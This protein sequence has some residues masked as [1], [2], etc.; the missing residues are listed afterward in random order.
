M[1]KTLYTPQ[2]KRYVD[3]LNSH[4]SFTC[5]EDYDA[6]SYE[7]INMFFKE[8]KK[9]APIDDR[10]CR[11]FWVE[12]ERGPISA[13]GD[14][15]EWKDLGEVKNRKEFNQLWLDYYPNPT[16]WFNIYA[17]EDEESD[18]KAIAVNER[19]IIQIGSNIEKKYMREITPFT[20]WLVSCVQDTIEKLKAGTYMPYIRENLPA[21]RRTG[22]ILREDFWDFYDGEKEAYFKGLTETD[23]AEFI[24]YMDEQNEKDIKFDN[25]IHDMTANDFFR[26][27]ALG[28]AAMNYDGCDLTPKEQ[29]KKHA[30]GRDEGLLEIDAD[31]P[32]A[33]KSWLTDRNRGGGHPWEVCRGGNSTHIDLM[34]Y[35]KDDGYFLYLRGSA[36]TRSSEAIKFYLALRRNNIPVI[37]R[38]GSV[39][40]QRVLGTE[41]VGVVP[42][43]VIPR[44]CESRFPDDNI[45]SFINLPYENTDLM[46]A[47]CIW[48]ELDEIKLLSEE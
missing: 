7:N 46:A 32:S 9:I 36:Y 1:P 4:R 43:G 22:I 24:S 41:K 17:Y 45:T 8:L 33:F 15:E 6:K 3:T 10:G 40:K 34:V 13:F 35:H 28:Y 26:C 38:D 11:E 21:G 2:I 25:Y 20:E 16:S 19:M 23:I 37:L 18:Y 14:Y 47:K 27:C 48:Q 42:Q 31:S 44:Y 29:Y 30:D 39:L 5:E 12:T